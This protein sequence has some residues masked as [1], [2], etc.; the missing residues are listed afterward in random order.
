MY[1]ISFSSKIIFSNIYI[2]FFIQSGYNIQRIYDFNCNLKISCCI[3]IKTMGCFMSKN[4]E[5]ERALAINQTV[6]D[7]HREI[8]RLKSI[9]DKISFDNVF[10]KEKI[11]FLELQHKRV[12][13]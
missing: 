13:V 1:I 5:R 9:S 11:S 8:N 10:L 2:Y 4:A 7:L 6:G 3:C 12:S